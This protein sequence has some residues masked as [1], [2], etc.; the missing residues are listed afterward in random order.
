MRFAPLN[1]LARN[2]GTLVLSF[3][4]A[5]VV[6]VSAVVT[7]DPNE[8]DTFRPVTI[9][10]TGQDP[11]LLL[12]GEPPKLVRLTLVAP[13]SI[14]NQL[15]N[16]PDLVEAWVDLAGLEAGEHTVPVKVNVGASPVRFVKIEPPEINLSLEP[17]VS[18][19]FE[20]LVPVSGDLPLG[21]KEGPLSIE[22]GV[23]TVS[24]AES[25]VAG[26][27]QVRT[28]LDIAGAT[29]TIQKILPVVAV[30]AEGNAIPNLTILPNMVTVTQPI[31]LLGGFKNVAVKVVTVGQ[32]ANG[33]RLTNIQVSPPTV[34]LFSDN[35]QLMNEIPGFVETQPVDLTNLSDDSEITVGLNLPE[36]VST[37]REPNV[38]VQIS[39]AAIEGSLTLSVPV[40]VVGLAPDLQANLSPETVDVIVAG[41]LNVLEQLTPEDFRVILDLSGL[42]PGVYQRAPEVEFAPEEVRVQ[43]TLP[44]MVEVSI[45]PALTP[46]PAPSLPANLLLTPTPLITPTGT[47]NP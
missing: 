33:Y 17:M 30:D 22:P 13:K 41:P 45:E 24:G 18:R 16:N 25:Q 31:S 2:F 14:W 27:V 11:N 12:V 19:N 23:V 39:V 15:N 29:E 35:P 7:A 47:S 8:E 21:Y 44:E 4:L 6:W 38:L 26:V 42:P 43:T 10:Y 5:L 34:T 37:V 36:G 1:W 46:T 20:V 32:V 28:T 40:Q 3:F 9:E